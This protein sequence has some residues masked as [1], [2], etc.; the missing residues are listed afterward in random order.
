[1]LLLRHADFLPL[2]LLMPMPPRLSHSRYACFLM[3]PPSAACLFFAP[4]YVDISLFYD[5]YAQH[6][7]S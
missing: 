1:M 4:R 7:D 3:L 5:V 6:V 2:L